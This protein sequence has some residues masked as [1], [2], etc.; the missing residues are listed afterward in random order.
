MIEKMKFL[1]ITGLKSDLDRVIEKYISKYDI[2]IENTLSELKN[3]KNLYPYTENNPYLESLQKAEELRPY[4]PSG[5]EE[6]NPAIGTK[7]A[8]ELIKRI[9]SD[10]EILRQ[11]LALAKKEEEEYQDKLCKVE[12]FIGLDYDIES[13]LHFKFITFRFGRISMEYYQK[14]I[15]FVYEGIDSIFYKCREIDGYVWG[16][17]FVPE[18][19]RNKVDAIYA[20]MHFERFYLPEGYEGT[21]KQA[22]S[23]LREKIA[24]KREEI[25]KINEEIGAA[26]GKEQ[27]AFFAAYRKLKFYTKHF[28][29]RKLAACTKK[30]DLIFY[31]VCGWMS[32]KDTQRFLKDIETDKAV[33]CIVEND[34]S[35]ITNKPPTRLKNSFLF[36]PFELF[37]EMY[38]LPDTK[39]FDPT[40]LVALSYCMLFGIMFAD[41]GQGF[42]L[43]LFGGLFA[44]MKKSKLAAIISRCGLFSMLCGFLFGSIFGFEDIIEPLWLRPAKSMMRLPLIGSINTIFVISILFGAGIIILSMLLN[45][46][47]RIRKKETP[48][49]LFETNGVAG[50]FFY[51]LCVLSIFLM[52][53][54]QKLPGIIV[55]FFILPLAAIFLKEP[56]GNL[57]A[58][59][60]EIF[61][62]HKAMF[63]VQGFFELFEI[64]LSYFSNTLSFVRVGAFA[65]SHAAIME[66]VLMLAGAQSGKINIWVLALGNL[67]VC[68]IEGLIVGI[69]VLRLE[70]YELFSRFYLGSGRAFK[71]Y[72]K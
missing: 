72:G 36:R 18:S 10:I 11:K 55:I 9:Y 7:E 65:V 70:Y 30:S 32:E 4:F 62:E 5:K 34:H 44:L 22:S 69:Q 1:S 45:T 49:A 15:D 67:F 58:K 37:V 71:P 59:K 63:I 52:I 47:S 23:S 39:E 19:I 51:L 57:L 17:Y 12:Q 28:G 42:L 25:S 54:G 46:A 35:N 68:L 21:P 29:I 38:G 27:E 26:I 40:M 14:F 60:K 31:I 33:Y 13:L 6:Q 56:L 24:K 66:V 20:S 43:A 2:Q 50:L 64:L 61:P 48:E 53:R 16:V 8:D 41:V 3:V